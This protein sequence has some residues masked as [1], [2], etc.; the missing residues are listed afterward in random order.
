MV[1]GITRN[2]PNPAYIIERIC[3]MVQH[4]KVTIA[5]GCR[6]LQAATLGNGGRLAPQA[7]VFSLFPGEPVLLG[8]G[9]CWRIGH[10]LG[11]ERSVTVTA[12]SPQAAARAP[13]IVH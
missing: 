10:A 7:S 4:L 1:A 12:R 11:E 2:R 3:S 5:G 9:P 6:R 8:R 13:S